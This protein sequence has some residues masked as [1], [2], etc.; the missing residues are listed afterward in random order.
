M[1]VKVIQIEDGKIKDVGQG[2]ENKENENRVLDDRVLDEDVKEFERRVEEEIERSDLSFVE[3][4]KLKLAFHRFF[5]LY[6]EN[7]KL[8]VLEHEL[9]EKLRKLMDSPVSFVREDGYRIYN[10]FRGRL[11]KARERV[12]MYEAKFLRVKEKFWHSQR[13]VL[14]SLASG[15]ASPQ[16]VANDTLTLSEWLLDLLRVLL[17]LGTRKGYRKAIDERKMLLSSLKGLVDSLIVKERDYFNVERAGK[18]F[19][20]IEDKLSVFLQKKGEEVEK[21]EEVRKAIDMVDKKD[22][23]KEGGD[24]KEKDEMKEKG[25]MKEKGETKEKSKIEET[26]ESKTFEKLDENS[27]YMSVRKKLI[28]FLKKKTQGNES[29]LEKKKVGSKKR[30]SNP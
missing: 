4:A 19:L 15:D 1:G 29:L 3:K 5:N 7:R 6:R 16:A 18:D 24:M 12:Q 30:R 13:A 8:D 26:K 28:D 23:M 25:D 11:D 17:P 2:L 9:N 14:R 22:E 20:N 10:E 27:H 21:G